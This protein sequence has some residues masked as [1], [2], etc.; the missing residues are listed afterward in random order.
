MMGPIAVC[1]TVEITYNTHIGAYEVQ[2]IDTSEM[3]EISIDRLI[4]QRPMDVLFCGNRKVLS[5][6]GL[7]I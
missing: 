3:Q 7:L 4:N 1:S 6:R 5:Q 2:R